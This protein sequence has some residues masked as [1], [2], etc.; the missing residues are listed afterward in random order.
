MIISKTV[1]II[2]SFLITLS[3]SYFFLLLF[4]CFHIQYNIFSVQRG[5]DLVR[6]SC[7]RYT[8]AATGYRT[9]D[10]GNIFLICIF[11]YLAVIARDHVSTGLFN[12]P[13]QFQRCLKDYNFPLISICFPFCKSL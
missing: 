3:T 13:A 5:L 6:L 10:R 4:T 9:R 11:N 2:N 1:L 12:C 7:P 8:I